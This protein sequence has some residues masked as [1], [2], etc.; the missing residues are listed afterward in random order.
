VKRL[1]ADDSAGS[2]VKVGNRQAVTPQKAL[3]TRAGLFA[4]V[5]PNRGYRSD[6]PLCYT[7]VEQRTL[8]YSIQRH[9]RVP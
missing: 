2:R 5:A 7:L 4:F 9:P 6:P 3:L 8:R 1:H